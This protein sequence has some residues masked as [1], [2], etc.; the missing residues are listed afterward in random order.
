MDDKVTQE[1]ELQAQKSLDLMS[2]MIVLVYKW[3]KVE[4]VERQNIWFQ[5]VGRVMSEEEGVEF[6]QKAKELGLIE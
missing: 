6:R 5:D 1:L 3:K 4:F 2:L